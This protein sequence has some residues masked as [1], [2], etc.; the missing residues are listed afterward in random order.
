MNSTNFGQTEN[1]IIA[2]PELKVTLDLNPFP[3]GHFH[4]G[5]EVIL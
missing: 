2:Q 4:G 1:Y 5:V 3:L